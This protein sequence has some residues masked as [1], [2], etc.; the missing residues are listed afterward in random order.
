MRPIRPAVATQFKRKCWLAAALKTT[1]MISVMMSPNAGS[2]SRNQRPKREPRAVAS[3]GVLQSCLRCA[4]TSAPQ[5]GGRRSTGGRRSASESTPGPFVPAVPDRIIATGD[6]RSRRHSNVD[7]AGPEVLRDC[8]R[9][10]SRHGPKS[11]G[12][13]RVHHRRGGAASD[14]N[15]AA[16][17]PNLWPNIMTSSLRLIGLPF[18]PR[19]RFA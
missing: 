12:L 16:D 5:Q 18:G 1:T 6:E 9:A 19:P 14:Q 8:A 17:L 2:S 13:S 3:R 10:R 15:Q 11:R 4:R 7:H